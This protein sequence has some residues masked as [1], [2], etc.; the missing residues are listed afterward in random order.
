MLLEIFREAIEDP[1]FS[2]SVFYFA[3]HRA[4][5]NTKAKIEG[6]P[7]N[8]SFIIAASSIL[9]IRGIGKRQHDDFIYFIVVPL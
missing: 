1:T 2:H 4:A 9:L 6:Q 8:D 7:S 5:G 3:S